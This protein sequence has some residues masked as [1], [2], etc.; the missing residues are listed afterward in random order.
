M[1]LRA[2]RR[3]L[4]RLRD[5][6]VELG[7]DDG[8]AAADEGQARHSGATDP[9]PERSTS[10]PTVAPDEEARL[11]RLRMRGVVDQMQASVAKIDNWSI[12]L[13]DIETGLIDFPALASGRQIWLCWR[14]G[15]DAI[16]SWHGLD[17]GFSGR[18]PLAELT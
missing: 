9:S 16:D 5:R 6:L 4:I 14:L 11:I 13:R 10:S 3:E 7:V 2:Q 1:L 17:E 12:T 8:P 18:H 15:E